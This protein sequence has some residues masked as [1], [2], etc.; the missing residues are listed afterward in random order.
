[1]LS[2]TLQNTTDKFTYISFP[3]AKDSL[4]DKKH[5]NTSTI[6]AI[7]MGKHNW[8]SEFENQQC[9]NRD[10]KYLDL[11][12]EFEHYMLN[13]L[14]SI[15]PQIKDHIVYTEVSTPLST[16]HFS[17]Y[18]KGEIYGLNHTP[19]RFVLPFL[20][21]DTKIKGLK[22]TGQDITLV[23]IGGAMSS[24]LLTVISILKMKTWRIFSP[25]N[26]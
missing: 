21:P 5:K 15:L 26:S 23:G 12:K 7:S 19:E 11:E 9:M 3:S 20:R 24:G 18:Q 16:Q 2:L 14:Y 6:Q 10:Q 8:F 13:K 25:N 1:M 22:L 4:W 17:N